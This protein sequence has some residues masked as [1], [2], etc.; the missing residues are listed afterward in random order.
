MY[1]TT[2][3]TKPTIYRMPLKEPLHVEGRLVVYHENY[4]SSSSF[5]LYVHT[6]PQPLYTPGEPYIF[7]GRK[8]LNCS[9]RATYSL[10]QLG[11]M[12]ATISET[13]L[14]TAGSGLLWVRLRGGKACSSTFAE[15][16]ARGLCAV[17]VSGSSHNIS[18]ASRASISQTKVVVSPTITFTRDRRLP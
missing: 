15:G 2:L 3:H 12:G 7:P 18:R 6:L 10:L 5:K 9:R 11:A 16:D 4:L 14:H 13:Y 1:N 8:T 17:P